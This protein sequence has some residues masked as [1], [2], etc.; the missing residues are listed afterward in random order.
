MRTLASEF[1]TLLRWTPRGDLFDTQRRRS[2]PAPSPPGKHAPNVCSKRSWRGSLQVGKEALVRFRRTLPCGVLS[3]HRARN[4]DDCGID[5]LLAKVRRRELHRPCPAEAIVDASRH[6]RHAEQET[7]FHFSANSS[8]AWRRLRRLGVDR[9]RKRAD[10]NI[11]SI[12]P[13][14]ATRSAPTRASSQMEARWAAPVLPDGAWAGMIRS[15]N[16]H[17]VIRRIR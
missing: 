11:R 5:R 13:I 3:R 7:S 1:R 12:R 17:V 14:G 6:P 9:A 15:H 16:S 8:T 10:L 4:I 2:A